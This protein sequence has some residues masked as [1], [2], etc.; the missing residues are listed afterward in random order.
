MR[1]S[2]PVTENTS[3]RQSAGRV[4]GKQRIE[5]R[6]LKWAEESK[7]DGPICWQNITLTVMFLSSGDKLQIV[8]SVL[9]KDTERRVSPCKLSPRYT[10]RESNPGPST[11]TLAPE[12]TSHVFRRSEG[13]FLHSFTV[14]YKKPSKVR[15][16]RSTQSI[17]NWCSQSWCQC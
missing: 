17:N 16:V 15:F 11:K 9:V 10:S 5:Q 7:P 4:S 1:I 2:H 12:K 14:R 6:R 8:A 3:C 13:F